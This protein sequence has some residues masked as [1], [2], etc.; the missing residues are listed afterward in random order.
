M[1]VPMKLSRK[2]LQRPRQ[3]AVFPYRLCR[4]GSYFES[5]PIAPYWPLQ[6]CKFWALWRWL[7]FW[8]KHT[9]DSSDFSLVHLKCWESKIPSSQETLKTH[10]TKRLFF[11]CLRG[12][13]L[14][15][16]LFVFL[17]TI[18]AMIHSTIII[19]LHH[20]DYV[21]ARQHRLQCCV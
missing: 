17:Q 14:N 9:P 20:T 18:A 1:I 11:F 8:V 5:T 3:K 15:S 10:L 13:K 21:R 2:C 19:K 16:C 7:P 4:T 6:E 12:L